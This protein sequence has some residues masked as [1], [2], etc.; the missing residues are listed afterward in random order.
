M[1]FIETESGHFQGETFEDLLN[2]VEFSL[3]NLTEKE[4]QS[5]HA[6]VLPKNKIRDKGFKSY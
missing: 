6:A 1:S 5:R 3:G 4:K 2:S